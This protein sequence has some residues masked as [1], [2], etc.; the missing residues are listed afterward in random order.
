MQYMK[1]FTYFA[2]K[3]KTG[4][5]NVGIGCI[6]GFVPVAGQMVWLGYR[7]EVSD[8]LEHDPT[9]ERY[10]DFNA[11]HLMPYLLRGIW[12]WL[13][14][15]IVSLCIAGP[16]YILSIITGIYIIASTGNQL[17]GL[18]AYASIFIAA[19]TSM[20]LLLW[21]MELHAM[22]TR[23]LHLVAELKFALGFLRVVGLE[24]AVT[25]FVFNMMG[26]MLMLVGLLFCIVGFYPAYVIKSMAEQHL[27]LQ[28][29]QRYI[30]EGG[31]PIDTWSEFENDD[32][33]RPRPKARRVEPETE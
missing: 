11:D 18:G 4:W 6:C 33:D 20:D 5:K 25:I 30:E 29:Y 23:K 16:A 10:S 28:L 3:P 19:V 7:A 12:P 9:L 17:L 1:P 27:M 14:T 15:L 32:D 13:T 26:Q 24:T 2:R 22:K 31:K 21:P 8:D